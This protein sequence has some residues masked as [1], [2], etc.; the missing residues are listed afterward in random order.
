MAKKHKKAKPSKLSRKS[1]AA[2]RKPA[3]RRGGKRGT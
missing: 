3:I 2:T 1:A